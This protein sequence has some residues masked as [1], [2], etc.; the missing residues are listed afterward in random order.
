MKKIVFG[1]KGMYLGGTEKALLTALNN[2]PQTDYEVTILLLD[3]EGALLDKIPSFCKVLY[4]E[5]ID[6][7]VKEPLLR[8]GFVDNIKY[9]LKHFRLIKVCKLLFRRLIKK[10]LLAEADGLYPKIPNLEEEFDIA[11]S[12][13]YHDTFI[14]RFI[15][16]HVT[17]KKKYVWVHNDL[18]TTGYRYQY[19][20]SYIN[21]FDKIYA[22]SNTITKELKDAYPEIADRIETKYNYF[23]EKSIKEKSLENIELPWSKETFSILSV[24]RLDKQKGFDIAIDVADILRKNNID[25]TW[26]IL[27]DGVEKQNLL[28]QIANKKLEKQFVLLGSVSNPFPYMKGCS[29]YVQPSRHEGYCT[30]TME[31]LCLNKPIIMTKVSGADEQ[32]EDGFNG[33]LT[34]IDSGAIANKI[35]EVYKNI[36]LLKEIES[37]IAKKAINHND[38][39]FDFLD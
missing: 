14:T 25:F 34:D 5:N 33:W 11:V 9:Y 35:M 17:A 16:D 13:Q 38:T 29:L 23:D 12:A 1:L 22:V 37:N 10:D 3:K 27:G 20:K 31:A 6:N 8:N 4:I 15:A 2:F 21:N 24:G 36:A 30:T 39:Y 32:I 26:Y 28:K 18:S 19:T 7:K